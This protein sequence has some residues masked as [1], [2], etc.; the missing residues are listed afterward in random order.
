MEQKQT[1]VQNEVFNHD[2]SLEEMVDYMLRV[3][4]Q[5]IKEQSPLILEKLQ[6]LNQVHGESHPE[7]AEIQSLFVQGAA[8]L[9]QHLH[10]EEMIL[11]PYMIGLSRKQQDGLDLSPPHFGRVAN[12]INMMLHEH[13]AELARFEKI[14]QLT[15]QYTPPQDACNTYKLTYDLLAK[16]E[17][18]LHRHIDLENKVVFPKS[19]E[20]EENV[21]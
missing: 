5:Y 7:L 9:M 16:F 2:A 11:F 15:N 1:D 8:D 3:H 18:D 10:K 13:D 4:H 20:L 21:M 17:Q 19:I 12:P 6:R 14:S